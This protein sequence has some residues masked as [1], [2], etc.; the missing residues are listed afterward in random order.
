MT[1][2]KSMPVPEDDPRSSRVREVKLMPDVDQRLTAYARER[3]L[4]PEVAAAEIIER[5]MREAGDRA[6]R[7]A[8]ARRAFERSRE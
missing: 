8:D 3:R 7:L 2:H 1:R 4:K 6:M 5:E